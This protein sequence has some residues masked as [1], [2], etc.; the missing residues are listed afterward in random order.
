MRLH[1]EKTQINL[2]F[3]FVCSNFTSLCSVNLGCT[4][5]KLK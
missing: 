1:S 2:V 4:Q 5:K 3:P